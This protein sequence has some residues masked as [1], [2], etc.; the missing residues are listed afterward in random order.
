[1]LRK[2]DETARLAETAGAV[3]GWFPDLANHSITTALGVESS[4]TERSRPTKGAFPVGCFECGSAAS[5]ACKHCG[6]LF[7]ERHGKVGYTGAAV[8]GA[9]LTTQKRMFPWM[10][11]A[12]VVFL[13]LA[14]WFM[15]RP[16]F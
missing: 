8:C 12:M 10:L 2:S 9:C 5:R 13:V 4:I 3:V 15:F 1:M 16:F 7:C 6:R 11:L 14:V